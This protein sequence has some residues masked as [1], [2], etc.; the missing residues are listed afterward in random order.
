M[1][2]EQFGQPYRT[3]KG[4]G[5]R[6]TTGTA[7]AAASRGSGHDQKHSPTTGT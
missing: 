6:S 7:P 3:A 1:P 2:S 5:V 4:W